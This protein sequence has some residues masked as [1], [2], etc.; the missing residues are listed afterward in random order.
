MHQSG[1]PCQYINCIY[2]WSALRNNWGFDFS[3]FLYK[4][5][6]YKI[7]LSMLKGSID[8]FV[9]PLVEKFTLTPIFAALFVPQ[10]LPGGGGGGGG[11]GGGAWAHFHEQR[12]GNR[13]YSC[14]FVSVKLVTDINLLREKNVANIYCNSRFPSPLISVW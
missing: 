5:V 8:S 13:A 1:T 9:H 7:K 6:I 12:L 14:Y 4:Y 2:F 10:L 3:V 11:R